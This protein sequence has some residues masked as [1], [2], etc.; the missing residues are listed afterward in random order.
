MPFKVGQTV[1]HEA[2]VAGFG[3]RTIAVVTS[4]AKGKVTLEARSH[5]PSSAIFRADDGRRLDASSSTVNERILEVPAP[6]DDLWG[7]RSGWIPAD[8]PPEREGWYEFRQAP[9]GIIGLC[10]FVAGTWLTT[11]E[12]AP[13]TLRGGETWQGLAA[14][15]VELYLDEKPV[16][17]ESPI[18]VAQ[19]TS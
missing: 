15:P 7:R 14:D 3:T 4:V 8:A 1:I 10:Y 16:A 13:L 5:G 11:D 6:P 2:E 17:E 9:D 12:L 19:T 18:R